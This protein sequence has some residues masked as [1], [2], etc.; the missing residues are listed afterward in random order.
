MKKLSLTLGRETLL[1]I[2]KSFAR[3]NLSYACCADITEVFKT[4]LDM[5]QYGAGAFKGTSCDRLYEELL[6]RISC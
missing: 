2:Y 1:I 5:L 6:F 4:K 3:P